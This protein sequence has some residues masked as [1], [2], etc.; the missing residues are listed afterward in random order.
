MII[1]RDN[2]QMKTILKIL[3]FFSCYVFFISCK[4][5]VKYEE[6]VN[7]SAFENDLKNTYKADSVIVYT[8]H[9]EA[10]YALHAADYLRVLL[11]NPTMSY[12]DFKKLREDKYEPIDNY[13]KIR[14]SLQTEAIFILQKANQYSTKPLSEYDIIIEYRKI[15]PVNKDLIY[16][17]QK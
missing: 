3:L 8:Q 14:D 15:N 17:M 2:L 12:F 13:A 4:H 9:V 1:N 5:S 6:F 10:G 11:Y 16:W 7:V